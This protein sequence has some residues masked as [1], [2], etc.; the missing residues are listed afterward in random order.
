MMSGPPLDV[1]WGPR[2]ATAM[3]AA[4]TRS[5]GITSTMPSG[6]PGNSLSRPRAYDRITGSAMRNPRIQPGRGSAHADSMIDG[7]HDADRHSR[8]CDLGQRLLAQRL[9]ERVGVGPTDAGGAGPAGLRRGGRAPSARGAARS[10]P[11]GPARRRHPARCGPACGTRPAGPVR[12]WRPRRR[13]AG[14]GRR[15]PRPARTGRGRTGRRS[16]A[17]RAPCPGGCRRRSR[18]TPRR[19]AA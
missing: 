8:P 16:P 3:M 1:A 18:S 13:R 15:P 17:P 9:G 12:G 14:G 19:G 2:A 11:R 4:T 10:W 6:T 5:T 7:P